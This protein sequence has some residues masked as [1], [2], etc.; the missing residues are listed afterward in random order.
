[1]TPRSPE[2]STLAT[3]CEFT[4]AFAAEIGAKAVV[5]P[6]LRTDC[7]G[8]IELHPLRHGPRSLCTTHAAN[9]QTSIRRKRWGEIQLGP[10]P[11]SPKIPPRS[12]TLPRLVAKSD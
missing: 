9:L 12:G 2:P 4:A 5:P 10:S 3:P 1:M 11:D 6:D 7:A 8:T